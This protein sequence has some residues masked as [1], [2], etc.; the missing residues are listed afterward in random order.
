[1]KI[2][3]TGGAGYIGSVCVEKLLDVGH[4]VTVFDNLTEGHRA[5]VDGRATF[6]EGDLGE[7]SSITSAMRTAR[8]DV[9]IHLAASAILSE[10]MT[11]PSKYFRNNVANGLYLLDAMVSSDV[12]RIIFFLTC[13]FT[14][15]I[16]IA[17]WY[18]N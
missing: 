13:Y 9:V 8:P 1:M 7:A 14:I 17:S 4:Q 11:N 2:L 10:S 5:A 18:L 16:Y 12:K 6:V 3:A 15:T